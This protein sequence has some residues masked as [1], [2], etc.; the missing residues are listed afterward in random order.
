MV[1][2]TRKSYFLNLDS[3]STPLGDKKEEGEGYFPICISQKFPKPISYFTLTF[4]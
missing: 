3:L 1:C 2:Q 4:G